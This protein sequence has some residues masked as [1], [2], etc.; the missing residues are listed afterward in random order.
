MSMKSTILAVLRL[1]RLNTMV[2]ADEIV[3]HEASVLG[4]EGQGWKE[5]LL[6]AYDRLPAKAEKTSALGT[7]YWPVYEHDVDRN[8]AS[9]GCGAFACIN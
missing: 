5:G 1:L 7:M 2:L 8:T 6:R 9:K 4:V 3:W